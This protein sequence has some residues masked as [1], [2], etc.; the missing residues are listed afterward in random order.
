[1]WYFERYCSIDVQ[2]GWSNFQGYNQSYFL[3]GCVRRSLNFN[4]KKYFEGL[5]DVCLCADSIEFY[6]KEIGKSVGF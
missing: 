2:I 4:A 3:Q 1:M 5:A 6:R